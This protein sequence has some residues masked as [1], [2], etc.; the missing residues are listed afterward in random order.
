M[1]NSTSIVFQ[2]Q[3]FKTYMLIVTCIIYLNEHLSDSV[4]AMHDIFMD[5]EPLQRAV[6]VLSDDFHRGIVTFNLI[7]T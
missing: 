5:V 7:T 3:L 1:F 4:R 2:L 6:E